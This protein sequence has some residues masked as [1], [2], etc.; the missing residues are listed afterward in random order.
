VWYVIILLY[1]VA[2]LNYAYYVDIYPNLACV[3]SI[4]D[5]LEFGKTF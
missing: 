5:K 1:Y 3:V 2:H 4:A